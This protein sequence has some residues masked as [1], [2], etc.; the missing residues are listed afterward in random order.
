MEY[1][2]KFCILPFSEGELYLILYNEII[3]NLILYSCN[4]TEEKYLINKK[5]L[6]ISK[7]ENNF[8]IDPI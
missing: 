2:T 1:E 4:S 3:K 6:E 7:Q 8:I 5:V